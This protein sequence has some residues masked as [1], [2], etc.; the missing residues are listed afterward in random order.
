MV[1][2]AALLV[3]AAVFGVSSTVPAT[4][5]SSAVVR[6][7]VHATGGISDP[8]VTA[9]ND[10]ASQY[11]QL[12]STSLVVDA[13]AD[14]LGRAGRGLTGDVS[15]GTVAAQNLIRVTVTGSSAEQA[16]RRATAVTVSFVRYVNRLSARQADVYTRTVASKL[17]PLDADI[18]QAREQ[19]STGTPDAQR[20]A[21]VLLSSLLVQRQQVESS[22]AESAAAAQPDVQLIANG[23]AGV[24]TS[25][26]PLLYASVGFVIVLLL[27]GRLAYIVGMRRVRAAA[28]P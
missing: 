13:A 28:F 21:T 27:L 24:K 14:R 2:L 12:A 25:P 16:R 10:L 15:A 17:R 6:V 22:V 18:T 8:A 7:S 20:N 4:Y 3:G 1:L 23:S 5:E 26:K 9:A 19:L 11:A